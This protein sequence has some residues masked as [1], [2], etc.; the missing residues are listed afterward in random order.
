V[1]ITAENSADFRRRSARQNNPKKHETFREV[2]LE[3]QELGGGR[4]RDNSAMNKI[5]RSTRGC[6]VVA[7]RNGGGFSLVPAKL[8]LGLNFQQPK[9]L[10]CGCIIPLFGFSPDLWAQGSSSNL[11]I[12]STKIQN[13][14]TIN[15]NLLIF[16]CN[17]EGSPPR[18]LCQGSSPNFICSHLPME[19]FLFYET[20]KNP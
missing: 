11:P 5:A 19:I 10:K 14:A 2:V 9:R 13:C 17:F 8:T 3:S 18:P 12:Y 7:A 15:N 16:K 6:P 1:D 20:G 4:S